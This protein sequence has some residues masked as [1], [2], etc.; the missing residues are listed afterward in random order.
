MLDI[1]EGLKNFMLEEKN[2]THS[3]KKG[4]IKTQIKI[5]LIHKKVL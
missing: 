1:I 3:I 5:F 4:K 2:N